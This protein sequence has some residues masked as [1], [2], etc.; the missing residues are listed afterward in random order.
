[1]NFSHMSRNFPDMVKVY[2]KIL[3]SEQGKLGSG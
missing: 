2:G 1:M 3:G